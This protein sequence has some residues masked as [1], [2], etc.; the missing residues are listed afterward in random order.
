M[1]NKENLNA[2]KLMQEGKLEEAYLEFS[3]NFEANPKNYEALYFRAIID[4]GHLKTH[5]AQT[6]FDLKL[7]ANCK[8][9]FTASAMQLLTLLLD[10]NDDFDGVI[11]YGKKA[12][13]NMEVAN[14]VN[15][16]SDLYFALARAYFHKYSSDDLKNAL[17]YI[18]LCIESSKD[19]F[20]IDYLLIKVDILI[21]LK[22]FDKAKLAIDDV[23]HHFGSS[24]PL[25]YIKEKLNFAMGLDIKQKDQVLAEEY[26]TKAIEYLDIYEKYSTDKILIA[27]TK[28]EILNQ[29][30]RYDDSL[31]LL[32]EVTNDENEVEV[33]IE[34]IK[35]YEY[36]EQ[37]ETAVDLC[38]E[39]LKTKSSWK[40]EY[41]LGFLL[42]Y[43]AKTDDEILECLDYQYKAFEKANESFILYEICI[44]NNKLQRYEENYKL[45]NE[46]YKNNAYDGR[47]AY[48]LAVMAQTL[49]KPYEEQLSF[50][51]M[52]YDLGYIN[53]I[54]FLDDV[55]G[56]A[57]DPRPYIKL[58]LKHKNDDL[59]ILDPWSKRKMAIRYLYGDDGYKQ[60][61]NKAYTFL[62]Y[63]L[64][65]LPD[66]SCIYS[67]MGKYYEF[68]N[69]PEDAFK[70]Y[71][72]AYGLYTLDSYNP[73]NCASSYLAHAYLNGIG[74]EKDVAK[75]KKLVLE[76]LKEK[77][78]YSTN[79]IFYL[80]AYFAL[81]LEEG[82][83]LAYA[84]EL[85]ELTSTF[86]RY[87]VSKYLM[88]SKINKKLKLD[89]KVNQ[90]RLKRALKFADKYS[91]E[92]YKKNKNKAIIYPHLKDF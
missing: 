37:Y 69:K 67:S 41:S 27:F 29:L 14:G 43:N 19:E 83:D 6:I 71:E 57:E 49:S 45:L 68:K 39:Y 13:E 87:E 58:A 44:L 54:E 77:G 33:M 1:A 89:D 88:I 40:I 32:D 31:K 9:N 86:N 90:K 82:F 84:K 23:Q 36:L 30:K 74:V 76:A 64:K 4:F 53:E 75:A 3:N 70:L 10:V 91:K 7:L 52:S 25:Y 81:T 73:C 48:L 24:G 80:Y 46:F 35:I 55:L 38:R 65:E 72:K 15:F 60:D 79:G 62:E 16:I 8:N 21:G 2:I 5:T 51:K 56:L 26:F 61:F 34:K 92:Y 11:Y 47:G 50:Y 78:K 20:E 59:E 17:K 18:N 63:A 28:V 85:L 12:I 42:A 22:E 66:K